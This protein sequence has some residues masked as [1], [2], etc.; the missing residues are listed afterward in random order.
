MTISNKIASTIATGALL[1]SMATPAFAADSIEIVGNGAGSVNTTT[2]T[3]TNNTTVSQNNAAQVT[4]NVTSNSNSGGNNANFNTG[5]DTTVLTGAAQTVTNVTT[6]V[7]ANSAQI[8]QCNCATANGV[9][10]VTIAGNGATSHNTAVVVANNNTTLGQNNAAAVTNNVTSK[11]NSGYNGA[12]FNTGGDVSILTGP[13]VTQTSV[14]TAG[15]VNTA[16]IGGGA[17]GAG[18]GNAASAL[19]TGNGAG[20]VNGITLVLPSALTVGQNNSASILNNVSS[21]ATSGKNDANF[22]TGGDTHILTGPAAAVTNVDNLVNFNA[23]DLDCTCL[24]GGLDAKIGGNGAGATFNTITAV[25]GNTTTLGQNNGAAL[26]NNVSSGAK[27]GY[28][29]AAYN[30][31][32]VGGISDPSVITGQAYDETNVSNLSNWNGAGTGAT[33]NLPGGTNLNLLLD[34][35]ALWSWLM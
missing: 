33:V 7:N 20:S 22:N 29:D 9:G 4:N 21:H 19:I 11:A 6:A 14:L 5:G 24:I 15:N 8:D 2:V 34:L 32:T 35:G 28:N 10:D 25:L 26:A 16:S 17:T 23:A 12:A 1:F 27:S 18:A 31:G 3:D 30:T 13:A